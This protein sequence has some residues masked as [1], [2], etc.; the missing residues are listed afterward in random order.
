MQVDKVGNN[1]MGKWYVDFLNSKNNFK[2]DRI[3]FEGEYAEREAKKW[4]FENMEKFDPDCLGYVD[5]EDYDLFDFRDCV[6]REALKFGNSLKI[7]DVVNIIDQVNSSDKYKGFIDT[8][9]PKPY[10]RVTLLVDVYN[11]CGFVFPEYKDEELIFNKY[12]GHV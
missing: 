6:W 5:N 1:I 12:F 11:Y 10:W 3:Y 4:C 8:N 2:P 7:Q 9:S